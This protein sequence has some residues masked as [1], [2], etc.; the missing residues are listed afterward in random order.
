MQ[1]P[2]QYPSDRNKILYASSFLTDSAAQWFN[3][4]LVQ[5]PLPDVVTVWEVFTHELNNMFGDRNRTYTAQQALR[6]LKMENQHQVNH[7]AIEFAKS[8]MMPGYTESALASHF[9]EGLPP[10]VVTKAN[11]G[12]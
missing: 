7:Y 8:G 1:S 4:Y 3:N 2:H 9:Y 12:W 11:C 10:C 5:E 6:S